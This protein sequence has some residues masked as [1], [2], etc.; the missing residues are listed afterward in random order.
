MQMFVLGV[1]WAFPLT[2]T[3]LPKALF[4]ASRPAITAPATPG[5][6]GGQTSTSPGTA[7][8]PKFGDDG[9]PLEDDDPMGLMKRK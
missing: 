9:I 7:A 6:D 2:A 8:K 5:K 1:V 3:W 4:Q